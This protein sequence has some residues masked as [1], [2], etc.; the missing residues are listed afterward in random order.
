MGSRADELGDLTEPVTQPSL[1]TRDL[2]Y[3]CAFATV[4]RAST[5]F[6]MFTDPISRVYRGDE[7]HYVDLARLLADGHPLPQGTVD[8]VFV[9][10]LSWFYR[11]FG[12]GHDAA[13]VAQL[14]L[15]VAAT[16]AV[17]VAA[18][19]LASRGAALVAA[20]LY[21]VCGPVL[22]YEL[23]LGPEPWLATMF[24]GTM[25]LWLW[26]HRH[27]SQWGQLGVALALGC[28]ALVRI[29]VLLTLPVVISLAWR[30]NR[31]EETHVARVWLRTRWR[32]VV[33]LALL[34][35]T[36]TLVAGLRAP[37]GAGPGDAVGILLYVGNT[38]GTDGTL[39]QPE[40]WGGG[41]SRTE[42]IRAALRSG[43]AQTTDVNST[44]DANM[45]WMRRTV[46]FIAKNPSTW[47]RTL[48][49]KAT[50]MVRARETG[51][52][53]SYHFERAFAGPLSSPFLP[54]G[55]WFI[56]L[57]ACGWLITLRR[58]SQRVIVTTVMIFSGPVTLLVFYVEARTRMPWF[59]VLAVLSAVTF[60]AVIGTMRHRT[61]R[62]LLGVAALCA[63]LGWTHWPRA[64]PRYL[65]QH[66]A[67]GAALYLAG[68]H[69]LAVQHLETATTSETL[70]RA[71]F[72]YLIQTY[73]ELGE[74]EL[75]I[76]RTI[77]FRD[78]L[79][80]VGDVEGARE[81][82]RSLDNARLRHDERTGGD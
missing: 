33:A 24:V 27:R 28:I 41:A 47:L 35:L 19:A 14:G 11:V 62:H 49:N 13:I 60:D 9:T 64:T 1:P 34:M 73:A 63:A 39:S 50:L 26:S 40:G 56:V 46:S 3:L 2:V 82:Q 5:F 80:S 65:Y 68:E 79:T 59:P 7:G 44:E 53:R 72:P 66:Y 77:A 31:L 52:L 69:E 6:G 57:G 36:P 15:G 8:P 17:A 78:R 54:N 55:G 23:R 71:A 38:G 43:A 20:G 58:P 74:P 16:A 4:V 29:E 51:H 67:R 30:S 70:W 61:T 32:G 25:A 45:L 12:D 75:A 76:A 48:R 18:R 81:A 21:A 42:L 10:V 37:S 22:F